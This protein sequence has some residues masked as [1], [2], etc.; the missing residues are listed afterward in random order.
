MIIIRAACYY[1]IIMAASLI[2][3][4]VQYCFLIHSVILHNKGCLILDP[5]KTCNTQTYPVTCGECGYFY[6]RKHTYGEETE[7]PAYLQTY[8]CSILTMKYV[9]R[10]Y[11]IFM[12]HFPT[13]FLLQISWSKKTIWLK[14]KNTNV[15][16]K[17]EYI[18]KFM[19]I[20]PSITINTTINVLTSPF[21]RSSLTLIIWWTLYLTSQKCI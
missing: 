12:K 2:Y 8:K 17:S 19:I 10:H 11:D 3:L 7:N 5:W 15:D 13:G 4:M 18:K 20:G 21:F 16:K 9:I 1:L 6:F 14:N